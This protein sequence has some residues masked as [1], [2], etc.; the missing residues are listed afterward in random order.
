[1]RE[2]VPGPLSRLI[3][4]IVLMILD[5]NQVILGNSRMVG[6]EVVVGQI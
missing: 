2:I 5:V 1:M 3:N 6:R 4:L